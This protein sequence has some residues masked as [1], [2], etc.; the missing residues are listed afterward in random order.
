MRELSVQK[1]AKTGEIPRP[2][3]LGQ[4]GRPTQCGVSC[5]SLAS[6]SQIKKP[7]QFNLILAQDSYPKIERLESM[8]DG[9]TCRENL[10]F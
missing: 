4:A 8:I 2:A 7:S 10:I 6:V 3:S 9:P 5:P 1:L